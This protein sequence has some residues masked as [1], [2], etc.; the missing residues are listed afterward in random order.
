MHHQIRYPLVNGLRGVAVLLVLGFHFKLPLFENGFWGVDLFFWISGFLITGGFIREYDANREVNGKFGYLDLR[1][2]FLKRARRIFPLLIIVLILVTTII[3]LIGDKTSILQTLRRIPVILTSTFNWQLQRDSN[4]YFVNSNGDFGLLHYWTLSLEEQIYLVSPFIFLLATSFHGAKLLGIRTTWASRLLILHVALS[5]LSFVFMLIQIQIN[6]ASNYYST[7][8]RYWQF[9]LGSIFA[10]LWFWRIDNRLTHQIK[11][12]LSFISIVLFALSFFVFKETRFG[13]ES[14]VPLLAIS[15]IVITGLSSKKQ[16][17]FLKILNGRVLQFLG[18]I[19]YPLY[20]LH[21]PALILLQN[22]GYH[23]SLLNVF[24][25]LALVIF[26]AYILHRYVETPFMMIGLE[27]F[28]KPKSLHSRAFL[29]RSST[30]SKKT[31]SIVLTSFTF[32]TLLLSYPSAA[33]TSVDKVATFLKSNRYGTLSPDMEKSTISIATASPEPTPSESN[34]VVG[35]NS[36]TL[37]VDNLPEPKAL[38]TPSSKISPTIAMR[39]DSGWLK[40]LIV[41]ISL[42]AVPSDYQIS[43]SEV[44]TKLKSSW[45]NGCLNSESPASSCVFGSGEKEAILVG[46]SFSFAF[47]AGLRKSIPNDWRLRIM[48]KGSCLPWDV[49]QYDSGGAVNKGCADHLTWVQD[50]IRKAQPQLII[51]SGADQWLKNSTLQNWQDG[52]KRSAEFYAANSNKLVVISTVPGSGNLNECI[53]PKKS[54]RACFGFSSRITKFTEYQAKLSKIVGYK[55][56][57]LTDYLCY[58]GTCPPILEGLPVYADGSHI[59][60]LFS[61]KMNE[62]FKLEEIFS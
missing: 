62:I 27:K 60:E 18:N 50:Y 56:L 16:G 33:G 31:S 29:Q 3:Y 61:V 46:D 47:I 5:S 26:L 57:D 11:V 22:S 12:Y 13:P 7:F 30:R 6:S 45:R 52:F 55:Y 15:M 28:R 9:G 20:L 39:V 49:V 34:L 59:S 24:L 19:S 8:A 21:W 37:N 10:I 42:N 4:S 53:E 38:K 17:I 14:L 23:S 48:T 44:L 51:S 25:Y 54:L 58:R 35:Q 1:I 32:V 40:E 2:Y 43:H 36:E 41:A